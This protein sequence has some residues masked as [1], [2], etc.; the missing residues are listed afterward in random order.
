MSTDNT[1]DKHSIYIF[2]SSPKAMVQTEVF[3]KNRG[4]TVASGCDFRALIMYLVT[5]SPTYLFISADHPNKKARLLPKLLAQTF[6]VVSIPFAETN[7]M[8]TLKTLEAMG[9]QYHLPAPAS[10]PAI[11]RIIKKIIKDQSSSI[12]F[13]KLEEEI[14]VQNI[15]GEQPTGE[16]PGEFIPS[17]ESAKSLLKE[18]LGKD[19]DLM[20]FKNERNSSE[21]IKSDDQDPKNDPQNLTQTEES[22]KESSEYVTSE[23]SSEKL[24]S[25][26]VIKND[27]IKNQNKSNQQ[28]EKQVAKDRSQ[29]KNQSLTS[30]TKSALVTSKTKLNQSSQQK[31][32]DQKKIIKQNDSKKTETLIIEGTT[33]ALEDSVIKVEE[34]SVA[35]KVEKATN[36]ACITVDSERFKGY[37]VAAMGKDRIVDE[38]LLDQIKKRLFQF[39]KSNGETL[40]ESENMEIKIKEVDFQPWALKQAEFLRKSV[41]KGDEI[42]VAFFPN[43]NP[44]AKVEDS[45]E[46]HMAKLS[47]SDIKTDV[48]LDFETYVHLQANNKYIKYTSQGSSLQKEQ[49]DRLNAKGVNNLHIRRDSI[50]EF[51]KYKAQQFLNDK[52]EEYHAKIQEAAT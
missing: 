3:L 5:K 30:E 9:Q 49:K 12:D 46:N 48:P 6:P 21:F 38:D 8:E 1:E 4:W 25:L 28:Q 40:A 35:K 22:S 29:R 51:K 50:H 23:A 2:K 19:S 20:L 27:K 32:T 47:L 39:L 17:S 42:A 24:N 36:V 37:L 41:H 15:K 14:S 34:P 31:V 33:Q 43:K 52:I 13:K 44:D 7:T 11:Q 16:T 26:N 45:A 18:L 10:G